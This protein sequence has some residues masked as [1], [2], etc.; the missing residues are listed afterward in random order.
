[1]R[2]GHW[3]MWL[4]SAFISKNSLWPGEGDSALPALHAAAVEWPVYPERPPHMVE[5]YG[6][7]ARN[8]GNFGGY[9]D[10]LLK[11]N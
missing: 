7:K 10:K 9:I 11:L 3:R 6:E 8:A 2:T 1:M 5:L 4:W